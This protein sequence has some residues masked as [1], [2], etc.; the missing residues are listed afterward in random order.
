MA[1]PEWV[2]IAGKLGPASVA[3]A[4]CFISWAQNGRV[5]RV[6]ARAAAVEDQKLR[7]GLL[8]RRLAAI[9]SIRAAEADFGMNGDSAKSVASNLVA[10][11]KVAE[12]VFEQSH[13]DELEAAFR[14]AYEHGV[15]ADRLDRMYSARPRDEAE[16]DRKTERITDVDEMLSRS[17]P[18][19]RASLLDATR[20]GLVPHLDDPQFGRKWLRW[21]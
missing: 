13:K 4:V 12:V 11:L 20:V 8:D 3:L 15:L 9:D 14:L 6:A 19:L 18:A 1:I 21:S 5:N 16:I 10:A 7:L 17:L 2:D